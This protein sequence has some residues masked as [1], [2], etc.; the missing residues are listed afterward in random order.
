VGPIFLDGRA[1][2]E[3]HVL[4]ILSRVG[5]VCLCALCDSCES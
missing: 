1:F 3:S 2:F 4:V 5:G